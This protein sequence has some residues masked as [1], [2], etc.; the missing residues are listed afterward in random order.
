MS[1]PS[2]EQER[3]MLI[4]KIA[5]IRDLIREEWLIMDL[6]VAKE[7]EEEV[8]EAENRLASVVRSIARRKR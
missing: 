3:D 8:I 4:A 6:V 5:A 2:L 7:R 1:K